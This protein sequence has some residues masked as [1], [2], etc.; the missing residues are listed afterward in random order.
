MKRILKVIIK[1]LLILV[2]SLTLALSEELIR[3]Y[4]SPSML[5]IGHASVKLRSAEGKVIYIDPYF[6]T[7]YCYKE[8]ADYILVTHGHSDH[9]ITA[10][11]SKKDTCKTITWN[12]AQ[13]D[14]EFITFDDGDVKIEAVPGGGNGNHNPES[15]VGYIVTIDGIS[16]YHSGDCDFTEDKFDL[17]KKEIDYALYTVNGLYTMGPEEATE[18]ANYVDAR[19]NI[20]IHGDGKKYSRQREAFTAN[21]YMKLH[22]NQPIILRK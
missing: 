2:I 3:Y 22:W 20:P 19:V 5:F 8:P 15:N 12:D 16:V 10:L 9:C 4:S 6:P 14:G 21:G 11:C 7:A 18:M 13:I 1:L 17:V